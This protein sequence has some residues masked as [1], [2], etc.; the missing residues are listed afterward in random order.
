MPST[1]PAVPPRVRDN[2]DRDGWLLVPVKI[3]VDL[4]DHAAR[5]RRL[6]ARQV[7]LV[8]QPWPLKYAP[9]PLTPRGSSVSTLV[10][11]VVKIATDCCI[12]VVL[13]SA[14]VQAYWP[15]PG[16]A[17]VLGPESLP[18]R[19]QPQGVDV[20]Y[21]VIV[22]ELGLTGRHVRSDDR[23]QRVALTTLPPMMTAGRLSGKTCGSLRS[24]C[25]YHAA[26]PLGLA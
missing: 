3:I 1:S 14:P 8:L 12:S 11:F 15:D 19:R 7:E 2:G 22:D 9:R 21:V 17:G 23:L 5:G 20:R 18:G 10:L 6:V 4:R 24:P 13:W 25:D 16:V 26:T